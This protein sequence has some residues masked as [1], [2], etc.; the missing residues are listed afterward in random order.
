MKKIKVIML[1]RLKQNKIIPDYLLPL[2]IWQSSMNTE[3]SQVI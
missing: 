1:A 2:N 3:D